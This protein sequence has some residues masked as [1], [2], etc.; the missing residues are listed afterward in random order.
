MNSASGC[1]DNDGCD[2]LYD[3]EIIKSLIRCMHVL[4]VMIID[5]WTEETNCTSY[6]FIP[7][8]LNS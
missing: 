7:Q 4:C 8:F 5:T 3:T 2:R 1:D 6:I